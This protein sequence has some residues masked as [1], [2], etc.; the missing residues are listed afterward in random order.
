MSPN[1]EDSAYFSDTDTCECK[2]NNEIIELRERVSTLETEIDQIKQLNNKLLKALGQETLANDFT[3]NLHVKD[4]ETQTVDSSPTLNSRDEPQ[5]VDISHTL[6]SRDETQVDVLTNEDQNNEIQE[7]KITTPSN[8]VLQTSAVTH[9]YTKNVDNNVGILRAEMVRNTDG[10]G[11][12][13]TYRHI[14]SIEQFTQN[15]QDRVNIFIQKC[16]GTLVSMLGG[17]DTIRTLTWDTLT[18][19]VL[20]LSTVKDDIDNIHEIYNFKWLGLEDPLIFEGMLKQQIEATPPLL[21]NYKQVLI[22]NMTQ[23]MKDSVR[24]IW[25]DLLDKDPGETLQRIASLFQEKGWSYF[26]DT[27]PIQKPIHK[28]FSFPQIVYN[29]VPYVLFPYSN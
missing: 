28:P 15:E 11:R 2:G 21:L 5:T 23:A 3:T 12:K 18:H 13:H 24:D 17:L 25:M 1:Y 20:N 9:M 10:N 27:P 22:H 6:N 4:D 7:A 16:E 26:F 19:K 14:K 29:M 8:H